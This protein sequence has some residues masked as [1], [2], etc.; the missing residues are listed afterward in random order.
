[1]KKTL[2]TMPATLAVAA[3]IIMSGNSAQAAQ[4]AA[5]TGVWDRVAACESGGRWNISTGNGYTGG[6]QFSA[7]SWRAAG[8]TRYASNAHHATKAQQI[9]TAQRLLKMQGPGAWPHCGPKA[10]LTK[11]NG[12]ATNASTAGVAS[13]SKAR[14]GTNKVATT[15]TTGY[16]SAHGMSV[17]Q[18]KKLQRL[19][20]AAVDGIVGPETTR[21]TEAHLG[22][23]KSDG[24]TLKGA[25]KTG[26]HKL[27]R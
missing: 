24:S 2:I 8:G 6:L 15:K 18:V 11:S 10:G 7:S 25:A 27:V 21:K 20:G 22:L 26:A 13:R 14:T 1:M 23:K 19:V 12:G 5:P 9:A 3:G 4:T 16:S 17:T